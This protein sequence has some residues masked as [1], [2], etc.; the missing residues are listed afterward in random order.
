MGRGSADA[1]AIE[2]DTHTA[3]TV[4]QLPVPRLALA[5]IAKL[6]GEIDAGFTTPPPPHDTADR[7]SP[8]PPAPERLPAAKG[9]RYRPGMS[10]KANRHDAEVAARA[11]G[12]ADAMRTLYASLLDAR[13]GAPA[14]GGGGSRK[15]VVEDFEDLLE[16][17][18][19]GRVHREA[20][21]RACETLDVNGDGEV[22][23]DEFINFILRSDRG[24][25]LHRALVGELAVPH[26]RDFAL[27]VGRLCAATLAGPSVGKMSQ[28]LPCLAARGDHFAVSVCTVD[29][30]T[31]SHGDSS[32]SFPMQ[33]LCRPLMLALALGSR[34][35]ETVHARVGRESHDADDAFSLEF[36]GNDEDG[37]PRWRPHNAM[38]PAG[39][40]VVASMV[41]NKLPVDQRFD[42]LLN[43]FSDIAGRRL[44]FDQE[45]YLEES[46]CNQRNRALV[47]FLR[48]R[49]SF[50]AADEPGGARDSLDFLTQSMAV[51]GTT[52][53]VSVMAATLANQGVCP[54]TQRR[55]LD[56]AAVDEVTKAIY[57][58]G[59]YGF[60]GRWAITVDL[61]AC[62]AA[63]GAI[64]VVVPNVMGICVWSPRLDENGNSARGVDFVRR[65]TRQMPI[66]VFAQLLDRCDS[67]CSSDCE[68]DT[69]DEIDTE[70]D[71]YGAPEAV[72]GDE[73]RAASAR[74]SA[75]WPRFRR[76]ASGR[77]ESPR[78]AHGRQASRA[79]ESASSTR[80]YASI[81]R[82]GEALQ[83]NQLLLA[84]QPQLPPP[85]V[86]NARQGSSLSAVAAAGA[87]LPRTPDVP[88]AKVPSAHAKPGAAW[89][90]IGPRQ[91]RR[92]K[93]ARDA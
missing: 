59:M 40:L 16:R 22:S 21:R 12:V 64:M 93:S 71:D 54:L 29:G 6:Y 48:G 79:D 56:P 7:A 68:S 14:D 62:S 86:E 57:V 60:S 3:H 92:S 58:G 73:A 65:L 55:C 32:V 66:G 67:D 9:R 26:F 74:L 70:E 85:A 20:V 15:L 75:R 44:A 36:A 83:S 13:G 81:D 39:A 50:P 87:N 46:A 88:A 45:V 43:S 19:L 91:K 49:G 69:D 17:L 8:T 78:R 1:K 34:G 23:F 89:E 52:D 24:N 11:S 82:V 77:D 90:T 10:A 42:E 61:P 63:S 30:Q 80:L 72:D 5:G 4:A 18:G 76:A 25:I 53:D 2:A 47:H 27:Q 38:S 28:V 84:G 37:R 33:A 51:S 41:G 35:A 31:Y